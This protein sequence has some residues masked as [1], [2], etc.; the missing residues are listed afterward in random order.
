SG[1]TALFRGCVFIWRKFVSLVFLRGVSVISLYHKLSSLEG[2][3]D[4]P[5]P[6]RLILFYYWQKDG[7]I[8]ARL[9]YWKSKVEWRKMKC[10]KSCL[11]FGFL[12]SGC[13]NAPPT[14]ST[15]PGS[16]TSDKS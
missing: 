2:P 1:T 5:L 8:I 15:R 13:Y 12:K 10:T 11:A 3:I 9:S 4:K 6:L 14:V 7:G 16:S